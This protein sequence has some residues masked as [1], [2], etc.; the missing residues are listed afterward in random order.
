MAGALS[1]T[2]SDLLGVDQDLAVAAKRVRLQIEREK[3]QALADSVHR[4]E[5]ELEELDR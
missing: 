2:P 5:R 3:L 1:T 4:M